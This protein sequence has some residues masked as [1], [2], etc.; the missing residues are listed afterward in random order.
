MQDYRRFDSSGAPVG[1]G[2]DR[3]GP[4]GPPPISSTGNSG[5]G[6]NGMGPQQGTGSY[7]IFIYL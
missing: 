3:W 6:P 7:N 5:T 2:G 4:N 1:S